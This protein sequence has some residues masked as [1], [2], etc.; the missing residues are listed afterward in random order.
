MSLK[1]WVD[2][3]NMW[4]MQTEQKTCAHTKNPDFQEV[5]FKGGDFF[6]PVLGELK[7][8]SGHQENLG[9]LSFQQCL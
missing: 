7:K 5:K 6:F 8:E 2:F 9:L 1:F 3:F 4:G